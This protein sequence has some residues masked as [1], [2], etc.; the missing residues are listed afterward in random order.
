MIQD[1]DARPLW[2]LSPVLLT[3]L[4]EIDSAWPRRS[5]ASDGTIGDAD[6]QS[7]KSDHTP[8]QRGY[9]RALDI[10]N[11]VHFGP[12]MNALAEYVRR[13]GANQSQ[14]LNPGG[15]VIWDHTIASARTGWDWSV[16]KGASPHTRHLHISC[17]LLPPFYLARSPWHI[18]RILTAGTLSS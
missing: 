3:L 12:P 2:L 15:Y 16:Y 1:V 14:R 4:R 8:D 17:S 13:L 9:V 10:T 18:R 11:D 7:R 5:R 6:H